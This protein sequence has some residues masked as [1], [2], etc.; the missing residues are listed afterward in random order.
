MQAM[1]GAMY[2]TEGE[3]FEGH[4]LFYRSHLAPKGWM[5][6]LDTSVRNLRIRK[7]EGFLNS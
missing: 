5:V 7:E 3:A 6:L 1:Q 4:S 2:Q